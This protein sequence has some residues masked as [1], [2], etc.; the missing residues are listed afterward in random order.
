MDLMSLTC[1][2]DVLGKENAVSAE[3]ELGNTFVA[4]RKMQVELKDTHCNVPIHT[5]KT[6]ACLVPYEIF[7]EA[8]LSL[9]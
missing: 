8:S 3:G 5:S 9:L 7:S 4:G 6:N 2:A 1:V